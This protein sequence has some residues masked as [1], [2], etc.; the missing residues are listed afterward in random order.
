[1]YDK[2]AKR[3][4]KRGWAVLDY[5]FHDSIIEADDATVIKSFKQIQKQVAKE[6]QGFR[7][8]NS[9][10]KIHLIGISLGNVP[11]AMV[12]KE[13]PG[14]DSATLVVAGDDLAWDMWHG[15]LTQDLRRGFEKEQIGIRRLDKD[16]LDLAPKNN[17]KNFALKP[18]K[19]YVALK[20]DVIRTPYQ[21]RL[22]EAVAKISDRV[23]VKNIRSGHAGTIVWFCLLAPLP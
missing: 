10:E 9:Y 11:L 6:L 5:K 18:V 23:S 1:L 14:F 19:L 21:K 3:L 2:L 4:T 16:W 12:C 8:T 7:S 20:D 17:L 15:I 13:F 22:A